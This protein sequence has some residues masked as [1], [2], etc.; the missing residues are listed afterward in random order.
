MFT[1]TQTPVSLIARSLENASRAELDQ[2]RKD[3]L[4]SAYSNGTFDRLETLAN[5]YAKPI[6][7]PRR[8]SDLWEV[9]TP[10][11][12]GRPDGDQ[13]RM[14]YYISRGGFV[15][16]LNDFD[17][18]RSWF[19]FVGGNLVVDRLG[20]PLIWSSGGRAVCY[21]THYKSIEGISYRNGPDGGDYFIVP[22]PWIDRLL[23][24]SDQARAIVDAAAAAKEEEERQKLYKKLC[25]DMLS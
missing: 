14:Y 7:N 16:R 15:P 2:V 22:G 9:T 12:P 17:T 23:E 18:I 5:V 10:L 1:A 20:T 13:V 21:Y 3:W 6:H 24:Y 11:D 8:H 4:L 25:I 19:I